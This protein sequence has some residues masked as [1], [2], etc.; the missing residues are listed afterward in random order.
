ML[1]YISEYDNYFKENN[2]RCGGIKT[3]LDP[4]PRLIL[5]PEV[6]LIA[7]GDT[8]NSAKV[9]ADIGEAWIETLLSAESLGTFNPISEQ[10]TF[11][12]E[13][14]SLEQAK[15]GKQKRKTFAGNVVLITGAGG[16]LG[17]QIAREFYKNGAEVV[18]LDKDPDA[19]KNTAELCGENSL[20]IEC[21]I[22]NDI[23]IQ[24]VFDLIV[25]NFGGL[26][27]LVSNAGAAWEGN[28]HDLDEDLFR[29]SMELNLFAH[30]KMA[31]NSVRIFKSQDYLEKNK[32]LLL[33][34]QL[35]FNISKQAINPGIGFGA[36]GI[37]KAA[38]LALMKQYAAEEGKSRIR[39]NGINADRI[40]SGLLN[41]EMIKSR[42]FA[43]G[44]S[45]NEYMSGNLLGSEV[46]PE[47]VSQAFISLAL[48]ERTTGALLTIDGGNIAA[49]VR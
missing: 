3:K 46:R 12:L 11:E 31:K 21:D 36:Y 23:Q 44:L 1:N 28:M 17:S 22:T 25:R 18:I 9:N 6:G 2:D 14:W 45:E 4:M 20:W 7:L 47:D 15:L 29:K 10:D 37:A 33:G 30:Q 5:L 35:L 32:D 24:N 27:I 8:K 26:D 48:M 40:R 39:A 34:G 13:Y 49:M 16:V 42:S 41:N 19:A 43:R 38:L